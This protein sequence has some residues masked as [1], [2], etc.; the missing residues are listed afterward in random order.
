MALILTLATP[1]RPTAPWTPSPA[2]A[3]ASA[4]AA[5]S[6]PLCPCRKRAPPPTLPHRYA[7]AVHRA[8]DDAV[9]KARTTV[10]GVHIVDGLP[11]A[12]LRGAREGGGGREAVRDVL[13]GCSCWASVPGRGARSC[14]SWAGRRKGGGSVW[15]G[16]GKV[17]G[18]GGGDVGGDGRVCE[19]V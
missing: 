11:R 16:N 3:G 19:G 6:S 2:S 9:T 4:A 12:A 1:P 5:A 15:E 10:L 14:G 18:A 17:G 13:P 7:R 8:K